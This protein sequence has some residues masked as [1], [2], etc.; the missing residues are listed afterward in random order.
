[1]VVDEFFHG[2]NQKRVEF[3][4]PKVLKRTMDVGAFFPPM[5]TPRSILR[6]WRSE[7]GDTITMREF[8]RLRGRVKAGKPIPIPPTLI[9]NFEKLPLHKKSLAPFVTPLRYRKD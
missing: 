5:N 4:D 3:F 1:M 9:I 7:V 8:R 6:Y 2:L